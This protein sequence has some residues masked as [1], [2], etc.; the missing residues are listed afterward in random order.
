MV[1]GEHQVV[2]DVRLPS[3]DA[4]RHLLTAAEWTE[5]VEAMESSLILDVLK[6]SEVLADSL[7]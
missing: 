4:L 1:M 2:A 5:H 3:K 6:Q 7:R